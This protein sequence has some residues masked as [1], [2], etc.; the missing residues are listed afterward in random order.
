MKNYWLKKHSEKEITPIINWEYIYCPYLPLIQTPVVF[1][2]SADLGPF[3]E[4]VVR[5]T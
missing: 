5:E 1:D 4:Q 3:L 2:P